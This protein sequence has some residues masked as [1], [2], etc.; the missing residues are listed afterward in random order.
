MRIKLER[1][2]DSYETR[3]IFPS[4]KKRQTNFC[5]FYSKASQWFCI[6]TYKW[7][8]RR[9]DRY[10]ILGDR[11]CISISIIYNIAHLYTVCMWFLTFEHHNF[12][13]IIFTLFDLKTFMIISVQ[14]FFLI[15]WFNKVQI[16]IRQKSDSKVRTIHTLI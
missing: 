16:S 5:T 11:K 12:R 1:F 6:Y 8:D 3:E 15:L 4:Y 7:I 2:Y 14:I 10:I 13:K 9:I